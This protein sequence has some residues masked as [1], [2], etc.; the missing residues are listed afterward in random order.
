MESGSTPEEA[1]VCNSA[2][3]FTHTQEVNTLIKIDRGSSAVDNLSVNPFTR[4]VEAQFVG[5]NTYTFSNVNKQAIEF[6]AGNDDVS[7]G[8][9][10]NQFC[11]GV[12]GVTAEKHAS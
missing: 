3:L 1:I 2:D 10:L 7:L 4:E 5:G 11:M 8:S 12:K 6:L 9:W